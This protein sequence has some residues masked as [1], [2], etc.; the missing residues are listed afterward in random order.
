MA[1]EWLTRTSSWLETDTEFELQATRGLADSAWRAP[2]GRVAEVAAL[3]GASL[4]TTCQCA[5]IYPEGFEFCPHCGAALQACPD[6]ERPSATPHPTPN[7][8]FDAWL[9][10]YA[11][12]DLPEHALKGVGLSAVSLAQVLSGPTAPQP[13]TRPAAS[14]PAPPAAA[15]VLISN[16][17]GFAASRLYALSYQQNV[18]QYFDPHANDWQMLAGHGPGSDLRFTAS[19]YYCLP[20]M[21]GRAGALALIPA[22]HGLMWLSVNPITLRYQ[23]QPLLEANLVSAPGRVFGHVACLIEKNGQLQL[24]SGQIGARQL[25]LW[26]E[27]EPGVAREVQCY[28]CPLAQVG[29]QLSVQL[30]GWSRPFAY[31]GKLLW[32]HQAGHLVWQPGH[33]PQWLPWP[34]GWQW[35]A[36]LPMQGRDGRLWLLGQQQEAQG[37][38]L[39]GLAS[40]LARD[41]P[42]DLLGSAATPGATHY[43]FVELASPTPQIERADGARQGFAQSIFRL[44]HPLYGEPWGSFSVENETDHHA[45]VWPLLACYD[46]DKRQQGAL[47]LRLPNYSGTV[48]QFL[49]SRASVD[50]KLEWIG[51]RHLALDRMQVARPWEIQVLL[52]DQHLWLYHPDW[53]TLR[54]W[55]LGANR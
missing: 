5:P 24:W 7:T 20:A 2:A 52:H 18:L 47:V 3:L 41:L 46:Q 38:L 40:D 54:G 31:Q 23:C 26:Q 10:P 50:A 51:E 27:E 35:R 28:P 1:T 44:G 21:A 15:G 55:P 32:L 33:A 45:L 42:G 53:Q 8:A 36:A 30:R 49:A 34:V 9:G 12:A 16:R 11:D 43:A 17:A 37:D 29:A 48:E 39:G 22:A 6:P 25:A 13:A 14:L 19:D 4:P